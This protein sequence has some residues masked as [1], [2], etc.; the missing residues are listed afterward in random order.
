MATITTADRVKQNFRKAMLVGIGAAVLARESA[1]D[2]GRK[3]MTKG[4]KTEPK[5]K[6]AWKGLSEKRKKVSKK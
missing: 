2:L 3:L 4:E 1:L 5:L 6:K